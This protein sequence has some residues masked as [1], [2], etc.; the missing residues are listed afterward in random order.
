VECEYLNKEER[1]LEMIERGLEES[2]K[3][4]LDEDVEIVAQ[5]REA[6]VRLEEKKRKK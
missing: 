3:E 2:R 1:G 4:G 5:L 6:R